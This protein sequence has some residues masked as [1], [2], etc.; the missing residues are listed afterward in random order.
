MFKRSRITSEGSVTIPAAI[1]RLA[2]LVPGTE[3]D[4]ALENDAV[5]LRP[6]QPTTKSG[7][8]RLITL[9]RGRGDIALTT[10]QIMALTRS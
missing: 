7:G 10:E 2:G 3:V 5:I 8:E 4:V 1:R 6:S 9:M